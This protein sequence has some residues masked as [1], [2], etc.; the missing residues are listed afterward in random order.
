MRVCLNEGSR[1]QKTTTNLLLQVDYDHDSTFGG[2]TPTTSTMSVTLIIYNFVE[3]NGRTYHEYKAGSML[4]Y[5]AI[6]TDTFH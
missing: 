6:I 2:M 4:I 1:V 3:E 5:T